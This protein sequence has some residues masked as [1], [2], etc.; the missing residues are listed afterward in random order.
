MTTSPGA[1][2]SGILQG[3]AYRALQNQL[4]QTLAV[5]NISIAEWK[6]LGLLTDMQVARIGDLAEA[7]AV[8]PPLITKMVKQL[9]KTKFIIQKTDPADKRA[10]ILTP[11]T[12]TKNLIEELNAPVRKA[13]GDLLIGVSPEEFQIYMRV[14]TTIGKNGKIIAI[15][16]SFEIE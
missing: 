3:K 9:V 11:T 5:F 4:S 1:Y 13:L 7:L 14:L 16:K 8:E 15:K 10:S 12:H 2:I 6:L